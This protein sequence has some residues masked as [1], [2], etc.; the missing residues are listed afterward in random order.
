MSSERTRVVLDCDTANEIDDQFAIAYALGC[1][2]LDVLGVVSVH[3]TIVHGRYSVSLYQE[4]AQK[5]VELAGRADLP[6]PRGAAAPMEDRISPVVSDG[7]EFIVEAARN[8]PLTVLATGPATDVAALGLVAP[9]LSDRVEIIWAGGF[10]DLQTWEREKFGELNARADIQAWRALYGSDLPLRL[11]PGWPGVAT[12]ALDW[13]DC[14]EQLRNLDGATTDYL[15]DI[16]TRYAGARGGLLDMD[17]RQQTGQEK[18]LWD[19]VNVAAANRPATVDWTTR[20]LP[21]ID[22]AGAPDYDSPVREVPIGLSV[23][24]PAVLND[25]WAALGRLAAVTDPTG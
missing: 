12:V 19:V 2:Q 23:D 24:A 6:C 10:P 16:L 15:A 1:D 25:M 7:L 5:V 20:A 13:R 9:E 11:L 21:T 4:E 8:A 14:V 18:V 22:P 17:E 3:N